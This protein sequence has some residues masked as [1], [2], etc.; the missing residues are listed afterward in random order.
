MGLKPHECVTGKRVIPKKKKIKVA[1][2]KEP[3][4]VYSPGK[5]VAS[6]Q[7]MVFHAPKCEWAKKISRKNKVWFNSKQKAFKLGY[8]EHD[9][10]EK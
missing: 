8:E 6:T 4:K 9:C 3:K 2:V 7:G 5:Y 10:L 1:K